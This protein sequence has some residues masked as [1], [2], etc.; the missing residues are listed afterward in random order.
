MS[1][2]EKLELLITYKKSSQKDIAGL[3]NIAT[4]TVA[5][6]LDGSRALSDD[7]INEVCKALNVERVFFDSIGSLIA[8]PTVQYKTLY[9]APPPTQGTFDNTTPEQEIIHLQRQ[10]L[11]LQDRINDKTRLIQLIKQQQLKS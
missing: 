11:E 4:S 10:I 5:R 9:N 7:R 3:L 8:E 1:N 2:I 6:W